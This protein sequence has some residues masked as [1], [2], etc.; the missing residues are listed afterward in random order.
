MPT[1]VPVGGVAGVEVGVVISMVVCISG[2][3]KVIIII[4]NGSQFA[5]MAGSHHEHN[6]GL[7]YPKHGIQCCPAGG[8]NE[9][10]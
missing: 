10:K 6:Q 5:D 4:K 2:T 9:K 3:H 1:Y 7:I 8:R